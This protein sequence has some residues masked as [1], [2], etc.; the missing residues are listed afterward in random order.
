MDVAGPDHDGSA[1]GGSTAP[2]DV[3]NA[4]PIRRV[5]TLEGARAVVLLCAGMLIAWVDTR[6]GWDD[7]GVTAGLILLTTAG[8]TLAGVP[9]WLAA[10]LGAAPLVIAEVR[11]GWGVLLAI[12]IALVGA[13]AAALFRRSRR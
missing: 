8:G 9:A 10:T 6:P 5:A 12:P 3:G 1:R 11:G 4:A 13:Y 2:V 7:T